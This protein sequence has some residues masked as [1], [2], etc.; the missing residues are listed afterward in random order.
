MRSVLVARELHA[1]DK[2]LADG[3]ADALDDLFQEPH[4]MLE[5]SAPFVVA[6]VAIRREELRDQVAAIGRVNLD[7]VVAAFA[8]PHGRLGVGFDQLLDVLGLRLLRHLEHRR[9]RN[10]TCADERQLRNQARRLTARVAK[11]AEDF[12]AVLVDGV[13]HHLVLRDD[14]VVEAPRGRA[15]QPAVCMDDIERR[16]HQR[17]AALRPLREVRSLPF[18]GHAFVRKARE[19]RRHHHAIAELDVPD[20]EGGEE[21]LELCRQSSLLADAFT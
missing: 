14:R 7:A 16:D 18:S 11:L 1:D 12:R 20:P 15:E 2:I 3:G 17:N 19:V 4:P 9:T 8:S 10:V 21:M 6:T 13:G 5:G